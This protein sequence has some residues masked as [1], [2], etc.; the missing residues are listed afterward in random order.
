MIYKTQPQSGA[1]AR[2]IQHPVA[3]VI[4]AVLV[5]FFTL[6]MFR[7]YKKS[8]QAHHNQTLQS[9]QTAQLLE[10]EQALENSLE[11][12]ET[13]RGIEEA[14]RDRYDIVL[15]GEQAVVIIDNEPPVEDVGKKS[16]WQRWFG[17]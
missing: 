12:L 17:K 13:E 14:L 8:R 7:I 2:T 5:I 15:E 11:S 1:F 6:S 10:Q 9:A 3:L 16:L 4:L